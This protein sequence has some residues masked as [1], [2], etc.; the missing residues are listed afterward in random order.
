MEEMAMAVLK[1]DVAAADALA[2]KWVEERSQTR[3][4]RAAAEAE[5]RTHPV[6]ADGHQV[7]QW[8]EFRA[9]AARLGFMWDLRTVSVIIRIT[10]G[11][12]VVVDHQY[13]GSDV[14]SHHTDEQS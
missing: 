3:T 8:P 13:A 7:Y 9:F 1:G 12:M 14:P 5:T 10:E 6:P 2:D 11:K 4:S